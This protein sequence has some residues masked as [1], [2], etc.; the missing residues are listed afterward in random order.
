MMAAEKAK[1]LNCLLRMDSL[2]HNWSGLRASA[3]MKLANKWSNN[4]P[5]HRVFD[6]TFLLSPLE[7]SSGNR[8]MSGNSARRLDA[9][10]R[11][12]RE[13]RLP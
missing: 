11:C 3:S 10:C 8:R 4:L 6:S 13:R 9:R 1:A 5:N 2:I 7:S 12:L